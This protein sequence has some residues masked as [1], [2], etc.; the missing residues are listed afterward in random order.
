MWQTPKFHQHCWNQGPNR[1]HRG[2]Y[3]FQRWFMIPLGNQ[4]GSCPSCPGWVALRSQTPWQL[5]QHWHR[6]AKHLVPPPW[7]KAQRDWIPT[8][9]AAQA[10]PFLKVEKYMELSLSSTSWCPQCRWP[11]PQIAVMWSWP[12]EIEPRHLHPERW[13]RAV[14]HLSTA[15]CVVC[16]PLHLRH[17]W[18]LAPLEVLTSLLLLGMTSRASMRSQMW[19]DSILQTFSWII[20]MIFQSMVTSLLSCCTDTTASVLGRSSSNARSPCALQ[21]WWPLGGSWW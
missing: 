1:I 18:K 15:Q 3:D 16:C 11:Q 13:R 10:C 14:C 20:F 21:A 12:Q 8:Q 2:T 19:E 4:L 9:P 7:K 17:R 5:P 6:G